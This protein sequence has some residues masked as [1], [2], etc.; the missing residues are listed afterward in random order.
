MSAQLTGADYDLIVTVVTATAEACAPGPEV[1]QRAAEAL[2]AAFHP[3]GWDTLTAAARFADLVWSQLRPAPLTDAELD[4]CLELKAKGFGNWDRD[5][6]MFLAPIEDTHPHV[7][8]LLY[9]TPMGT[10][11]RRE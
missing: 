2:Y 1:P 5:D 9:P 3:R 10:E 8:D 11:P 7:R 4:R 6:L